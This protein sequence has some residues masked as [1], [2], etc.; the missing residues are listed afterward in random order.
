M[1][2]ARAVQA[3]F[4]PGRSGQG[5]VCGK[6]CRG[7]IILMGRWAGV[8][9]LAIPTS[10]KHLTAPPSLLSHHSIKHDTHHHHLIDI[11]QVRG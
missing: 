6:V 3:H 11:T 10:K 5:Y 1:W 8:R 2:L 7:L 9:V 4:V